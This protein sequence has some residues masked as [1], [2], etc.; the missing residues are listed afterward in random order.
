MQNANQPSSD[1]HTPEGKYQQIRPKA[2]ACFQ[3]T[4]AVVKDLLMPTPADRKCPASL[5]G[6]KE[7]SARRHKHQDPQP[8]NVPTPKT[9]SHTQ[10][11]TRPSGKS[12]H[13][14]TGADLAPAGTSFKSL[15]SEQPEGNAR[16]S[17]DT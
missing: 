16:P 7:I 6:R 8:D 10:N 2:L 11:V 12:N 15:F 13:S 1:Q 17:A 4:D 9:I 3:K 14:A 5:R